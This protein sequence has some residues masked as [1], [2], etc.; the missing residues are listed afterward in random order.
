MTAKVSDANGVEGY[1]IHT[2]DTW[3]FRVYDD[4]GGFK[5]Y[6]IHHSDLGVKIVDQDAEFYEYE[7]GTTILDHSRGTLGK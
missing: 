6:D 7:D 1:L 5:D 2:M 4:Q 3:Q